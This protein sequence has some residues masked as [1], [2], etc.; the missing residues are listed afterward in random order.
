V[1]GAVETT[2]NHISVLSPSSSLLPGGI[3]QAIERSFSP[4][5][6]MNNNHVNYRV[7]G[8][9]K[10]GAWQHDQQNNVETQEMSAILMIQNDGMRMI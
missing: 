7:V 2:P 9:I 4:S 3:S 10:K 6:L 1:Y 5:G 8:L